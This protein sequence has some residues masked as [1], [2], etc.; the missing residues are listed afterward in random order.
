[1]SVFSFP[2]C[3]LYRRE[4]QKYL[5][6]RPKYEYFALGTQVHYILRI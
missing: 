2:E 6:I 3:F 5:E 1:M 4:S